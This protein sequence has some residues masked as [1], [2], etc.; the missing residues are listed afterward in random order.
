MVTILCAMGILN[1]R[2]L[3]R[4]HGGMSWSKDRKDKCIRVKCYGLDLKGLPTPNYHVPEKGLLGL[5]VGSTVGGGIWLEEVNHWVGK[6]MTKGPMSLSISF[7]LSLFQDHYGIS[8]LSPR[9]AFPLS[10]FCLRNR[11]LRI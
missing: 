10:F 1:D 11:Q 6:G 9:Q 7:L 8:N 5:G 3:C 4:K 2:S